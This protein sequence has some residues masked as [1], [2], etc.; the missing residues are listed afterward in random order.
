M[1]NNNKQ[2]EHGGNIY[3]LSPQNS[4]GIKNVLDYSANINPLGLAASVRQAI[5]QGINHIVH[6]PD[7]AAA[8]L[9]QA[10]SR[11]YGIERDYITVGNGAVELLYVL[12][13]IL[14]PRQVL[15]PAPTF[16]EYE[17]AARAAGAVINYAL[18][19][20]TDGFCLDINKI[21]AEINSR[22][23]DIVFIGNPNNPTGRLV[24]TTE[25][26]S[27]LIAAL[28][29]RTT[30]VI[31]ESFIDF[32]PD[33]AA[34]TTRHLLAKYPNLVVLHS[35]TK[36]YAIP[37]LRLGFMLA[38]SDLTRALHEHKDPWN[39]NSLAQTAGV[40]A[41][42]DEQYRLVSQ[43]LITGEKERFYGELQ[44]ISGCKPFKPA[45]NF[46]LVDVAGT[47]FTAGQLRQ[48]LLAEGMLVRDCSNYPGL[49]N[50]YI[51]LAVKLPEQN[52]RVIGIMKQILG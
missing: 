27:L 2:F 12:C 47:G 28:P 50:T 18:L 14:Q 1:R 17:R 25:L 51:R 10:I 16:S 19:D 52:N 15:V 20:S 45:V 21:I 9:K 3:A 33:A 26:E 36:I 4:R 8:A 32:L 37:G 24:T 42:G 7:P 40:A 48:Q 44:Q 41:L 30:V 35:L 22:H 11:R 39:V 38:Q 13:N 23:S 6:Y 46:I 43:Q 5:L 49:T 31:D 29:I 34:F